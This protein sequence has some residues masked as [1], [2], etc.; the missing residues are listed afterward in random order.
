MRLFQVQRL[1][2]SSAV[3][4][5]LVDVY[6]A[7]CVRLQA[8]VKRLSITDATTS[9]EHQHHRY[10]QQQQSA[11]VVSQDSVATANIQKISQVL[12]V[13]ISLRS[14]YMHVQSGSIL[15]LDLLIDPSDPS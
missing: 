4:Q 1:E 14:V 9:S 12:F 11:P 6:T 7:E 13:M 3:K 5:A 8:E 15:K 10:Q 2:Q